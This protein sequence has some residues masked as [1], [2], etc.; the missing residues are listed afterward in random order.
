MGERVPSA[1]AA[2]PCAEDEPGAGRWVG[3][4]LGRLRVGVGAWVG[5]CVWFWLWPCVGLSLCRPGDQPAPLCTRHQPAHCQAQTQ[6]AQR[7]TVSQLA[8]ARYPPLCP[9]GRG[10]GRG[11]RGRRRRRARAVPAHG[12]YRFGRAQAVRDEWPEAARARAGWCCVGV[13][14]PTLSQV[15]EQGISAYAARAADGDEAA[16]T[17]TTESKLQRSRHLLTAPARLQGGQPTLHTDPCTTSSLSLVSCFS[18]LLDTIPH[19]AVEDSRTCRR[20]VSPQ[21]QSPSRI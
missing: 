15:G 11:G 18:A 1:T 9:R 6:T 12:Y 17:T 3:L 16:A 14:P 2:E 5:L 7:H 20:H 13:E 19:T 10:R 8:H 21:P 4:E